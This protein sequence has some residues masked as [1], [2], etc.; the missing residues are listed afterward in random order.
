MSIWARIIKAIEAL[1]KGESL[2]DV[3]DKLKAPPERSIA[4]TI[5]VIALGAK[6]AK[7]D[8]YVTTDEVK[9]FRQ[10]FRIP[11]G[12]ENNAARV[13]NLAR[14]DVTG[15]ELYAK[16]ISLMFGQ[17]HQTL[18]DLL[19]GLF[20]IATADNDYHPNEDKFLS[21]VS[22][23]FGLKEAQFKAIRARCVPN[24]EPDP[25]TVL[26]VDLNDD[27]AKIKGAWRDLVRT[28]HP[29][30]MIARG[31]PEEAINLAERRIIQINKA[32]EAVKKD[33]V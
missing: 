33:F 31:L 30:R 26:G 6:M 13:F 5:A 23:I 21:M 10:V 7:A 22:S 11:S 24:M 1:A 4:F 19:E 8:G 28:Y 20:H 29:D 9:A 27:F 32:F 2:S 3:F 25:Y 16:R 15:Y 14:Q 12:E 17:G 18:V